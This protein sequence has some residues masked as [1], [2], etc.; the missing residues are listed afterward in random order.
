MALLYADVRVELRE[1]K[2]AK[3]PVEMLQLSPKATV[4]VLQLADG[5]VFEESLHIVDWALSV[6][7]PEHWLRVTDES[8]VKENDEGFKPLLDKYKY[9]D[10]FP[11][12]SQMAHRQAASG[13]L[14]KLDEKLRQSTFLAGSHRGKTDIA[15][16]PFIRQFAGVE[17]EW[18]SQCRF[19]ALRR[20]L[21][22]MVGSSLFLQVMQKYPVWYAG[23]ER[24]Y[25]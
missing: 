18:F 3:L 16:M 24:T 12:L 2:L 14:Y 11:E 19:T 5:S 21:L 10:R 23:G 6:A 13:F 4:P 17:P 15:I 20:W 1:V 9:A 8:L 25:I 7:D 22:V